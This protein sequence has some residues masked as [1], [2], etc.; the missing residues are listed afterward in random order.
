MKKKKI[1][2]QQ[3]A[4]IESELQSS[5]AKAQK[6]AL[7]K[8]AS[9]Y[10][11]GGFIAPD[12]IAGMETQIVSL[13]LVIGQD[14]KVVRWGLNALA[15]LGRW[16]TC[17]RYVEA[18][19]AV[20]SGNPEIEAAGVAALC[21]LLSSHTRDI[22]ALNTIDPRIWKLAAL[23]TCD[24]T[25]IDLSDIR[26]NVDRDDKEVLKLALITIG[27]NRDIEHLFDPSHSNGAFVRELCTHDDPIVQQYSVWAVAENERLD[28]HHLGL[29][30]DTIEGL[31]VNVQSKMYQLAAQRLPDLRRRL[32]LIVQGSYAH[33]V[34][35]REGLA[36]GLR[37]SYFD[38]L[39]SAVLPWFQQETSPTI[40]GSLAEHIAACS[41]ECGPYME[42]ARQSYEGDQGLR[43]RILLGAEGTPLYGQLR[44][45]KEPDLFSLI[46]EENDLASIIKAARKAKTMPKKS[47]CML[48]ASPLGETPLR[49]DEEVRDTLQKLKLVQAP[50]VE[51]EMRA[52]WA[53]RLSEIMDHLLN[54]KPKILHFSGHGGGGVILVENSVG[55]ATPLSADALAGLID[56]AGGIEC[57]VLNACHSADLSAATRA[58]VPVVIGCN[59]S[60]GDAAAITFTRSFYRALAH[61][62]D[63]VS[64]FKIAVADVRAQ[65]GAIEANKYTIEL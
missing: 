32:D 33:G 30:F 1:S 55:E 23:Q 4:F 60:I 17:Q 31:P 65:N 64:S 6:V 52:E 27:V 35:A 44:S 49:L 57:V 56:A 8:L 5:D 48:L 40:R 53:V 12:R 18:T 59:S 10:R 22:E 24:P 37:Y 38:G 42:A 62:R 36:K 15:Q 39:E 7:Q 43:G 26:I 29:S 13:L 16:T 50:S 41:A 21:K 47:V 25:R 61:G 3:I 54:S 45:Q 2:D 46:G 19:I 20:Y 9:L 14:K 51:I 28:L 34:E 63:Y 58:Y 11:Q